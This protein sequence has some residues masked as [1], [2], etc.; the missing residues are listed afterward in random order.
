[1]RF[2][3]KWRNLITPLPTAGRDCETMTQIRIALETEKI[4]VIRGT[5][6]LVPRK[7]EKRASTESEDSTGSEDVFYG[8]RFS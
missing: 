4:Y 3:T 2:L 6:E 7:T 5:D 1:M 8:P